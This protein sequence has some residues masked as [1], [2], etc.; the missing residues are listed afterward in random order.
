MGKSL[1][2]AFCLPPGLFFTAWIASTVL[3]RWRPRLGRA[4]QWFSG[5]GLLLVSTPIVSAWALGTLQTVPPL[6][7]APADAGAI[8]VLGG[9]FYPYAPEYATGKVGPLTL[10]RIR[11]GVTWHRATGLPLL[12]SAGNIRYDNLTGADAMAE[13]AEQDFG[14]P[15]RW[16]ERD[17]RT[18][19][20]NAFLSAEILR[21]EGIESIVLVT[22]AWH[23]PRAKRAFERAG[24]QVAP[25]PT[26]FNP[27]P[28]A[29]FASF[30]PS[31]RAIRNCFWASHEWLGRI[32]Y[33]IK[34][35]NAPGA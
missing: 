10:Q 4:G 34:D 27:P 23:M 21:A 35:R 8:V 17:S 29:R 5:F 22:T 16:R 28:K 15:V 18:T 6:H 20:E 14:V 11:H 30:L 24:F 9:D 26:A 19:R 3:R 2:V 12:M 31:H 1:F 33:A 13:C 7:E 32:F 25:A